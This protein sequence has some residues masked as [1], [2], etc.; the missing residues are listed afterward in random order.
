MASLTN[1]PAPA[2][3]SI[4]TPP[5]FLIAKDDQG[6][7]PLLAMNRKGRKVFRKERKELFGP[8]RALRML[9]ELCV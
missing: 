3:K 5:K 8:L 2:E 6:C 1:P 4:Q 7:N 9:C